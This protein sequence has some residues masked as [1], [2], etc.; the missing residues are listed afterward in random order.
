MRRWRKN[1]FSSLSF[2]DVDG[3]FLINDSV[4]MSLWRRPTE[5]TYFVG[6]QR[7]N[8]GDEYDGNSGE[9]EQGSGDVFAVVDQRVVQEVKVVEHQ[10]QRDAHLRVDRARLSCHLRR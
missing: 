8:D 10:H 6:R 4:G 9:E 5:T 2:I 3:Q 7:G 1:S